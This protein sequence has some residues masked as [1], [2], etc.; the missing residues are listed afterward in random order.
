MMLAQVSRHRLVWTVDVAKVERARI[1]HGWTQRRLAVESHVD[2]GTLS[3]LV[4]G[5]RR[6]TLGTIQALCRVLDLTL[7]DVIVFIDAPMKGVA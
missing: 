7:A 3:A 5:R 1:L 2:R 6:P 4:L